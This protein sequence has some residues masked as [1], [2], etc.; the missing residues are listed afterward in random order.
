MDYSKM[1]VK[2]LTE[3]K[4]KYTQEIKSS[5]WRRFVD[6]NRIDV[7]LVEEIDNKRN[8][9]ALMFSVAYLAKIN[10]NDVFSPIKTWESVIYNY[11]LANNYVVPMKKHMNG[12]PFEGA[13]VKDTL[14][15][16]YNWV[17][18]FD[19]TSM[20]PHLIMLCNM[21]PETLT[22]N[23]R[24]VN[25]LDLINKTY[26]TEEMK[27]VNCSLA[28]NGQMFTNEKQ[29]VFPILMR[30]YFNLRD[31]T[32]KE[33][34]EMKKAGGSNLVIAS[35][36]TRQNAIKVLLNSL[37][38]ALGNAYFRYYDLRIAEG[39]TKTGQMAIRWIERKMNEK[40][41]H[42]LKTKNVDYVIASDTDS[43][44][45]NFGPIIDSLCPGKDSAKTIEY[46]DKIC[47]EVIQPFIAESYKEMAE[48]LN[49]YEAAMHMKRENLCVHSDTRIKINDQI[50]TI[51]DYYESLNE[52]CG[53][54]VKVSYDA[55]DSFNIDTKTFEIDNID[56][57]S[58]KIN[59]ERMFEIE[60][61]DGSV[62]KLTENH[63]V[64]VN[65]NSEFIWIK[66]K[67]LSEH[68]EIIYHSF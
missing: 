55:I 67:E 62:L 22:G 8:V 23:S 61:E 27:T 32:K 50:L 16:S 31:T 65:R 60:L 15:G 13:Y 30:S 3:L 7:E 14:T 58:R 42:V 54:N 63:E 1:S 53:E 44:M 21:S 59:T 19:L 56:F 45:V 2:E 47:K 48:Y 64:L 37:Y 57:V 4:T 41:N 38:G 36:N 68:D 40:L 49:A 46:L 33:M 12:Q 35:L 11:L 17:V 25:I 5:S 24:S 20:Y 26:D 6:Y 18:T 52:S 34:L 66:T 29:G 9:L 28:A 39:I 10:Y 43:I 51:K